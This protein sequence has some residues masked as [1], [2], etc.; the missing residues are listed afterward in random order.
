VRELHLER[1]LFYALRYADR[2]LDTPIPPDLWGSLGGAAPA[3]P[4]MHLMDAL[5]GRTLGRGVG[6]GAV[7]SEFALYLRAHWLRMPPA[8]LARHLV[9][10]AFT[11]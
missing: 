1:P 8:L 5:V 3:R 7:M 11:R 9:R 6:S 2:I 4:V 10:K